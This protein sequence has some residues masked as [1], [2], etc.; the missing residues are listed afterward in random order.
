MKIHHIERADSAFQQPVDEQDLREQLSLALPGETIVAVTELEAGLFNNTYR[1]DVSDSRYI[2][3]VAPGGD[4][5]VFFPERSL[6]QR[7]RVIGPKLQSL[8]PLVPEYV[9]FFRIG[10]RDAFLQPFVE[11][12]LWHDVEKSLSEAENE[13]LWRQLGAFAKL[14]HTCPGESFGFPEP[15]KGFSSWSEFIVYNVDGMIDDCRR[16]GVLCE[17]VETYRRLLPHFLDTL[18]QVKTPRLL[19]GDLW[20]RNVIIDG[21]AADIHIKAV[22]D[23]ERAFWGD[24][25]SDWVLILYGIPDAF[26]DGYGEN[27]I[28]TIDPVR[29]TLYKG[30]YFILN[31]L[32]TTRFKESDAGPRSWLS[33]INRELEF[34]E[35]EIRSL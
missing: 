21:A 4:V 8:S 6:M 18:D 29:I 27:L 14:L 23:A 34:P 20:P 32:E 9:N 3:K 35:T 26:W 1:V 5:D 30:M 15:L 2:L 33:A 31:L 22:F 28:E 16:L 7:E 19:H 24:P 17:E 12:R 13:R 25:I 11:G 10:S